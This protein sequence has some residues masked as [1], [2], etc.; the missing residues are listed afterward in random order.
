MTVPEVKLAILV[1]FA[2]VKFI[3]RGVGLPAKPELLFCC[4][5]WWHLMNLYAPNP[6]DIYLPRGTENSGEEALNRGPPQG[7]EVERKRG[8]AVSAQPSPR[9]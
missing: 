6:I 4:L 2:A 8:R 7:T 1:S 9:A 3:L 5:A